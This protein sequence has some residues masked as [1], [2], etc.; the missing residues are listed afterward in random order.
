M[1]RKAAQLVGDCQPLADRKAVGIEPRFDH[2]LAV[3]LAAIPPLVVLGDLIDA[4]RIESERLADI[5]QNAARAIADDGCSQ[6]RPIAPVF[7]VD[8]LNDFFAPLMLE[9]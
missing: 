6:C 2:S 3:T 8:V 9:V 7:V 4:L 1:P 5:P